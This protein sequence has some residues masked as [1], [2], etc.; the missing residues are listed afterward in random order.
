M[1][2][3]GVTNQGAPALGDKAGSHLP[4][5]SGS[6]IPPKLT[7][8][9]LYSRNVN[10]FVSIFSATDSVL[11]GRQR[12]KPSG[13]DIKGLR[14]YPLPPQPQTVAELFLAFKGHI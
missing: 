10:Q 14:P 7:F 5:C 8:R 4:S 11:Q 6:A 1:P 9:N 12:A 13:E 2:Q 3:E